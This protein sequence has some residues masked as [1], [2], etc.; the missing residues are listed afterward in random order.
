MSSEISGRDAARAGSVAAEIGGGTHGIGLGLTAVPGI[1]ECLADIG[2]VDHLVLS[3]I[4]R[5]ANSVREY[6]V[7][8]A[9][10]LVTLK[11][12]GYVGDTP[13]REGKDL[14]AIVAR[15]PTTGAI[16][17]SDSRK[18]SRNHRPPD[19]WAVDK[20]LSNLAPEARRASNH[21]DTF[22]AR[23]GRRSAGV[24]EAPFFSRVS[25]GHR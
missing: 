19:A 14:S 20:R 7:D 6:D 12:A 11:M 16:W 4:A 18:E 13:F 8:R 22:E 2:E 25:F 9:V 24:Y 1:A 23:T 3:A 15:T 17:P 5:D 10:E 21:H